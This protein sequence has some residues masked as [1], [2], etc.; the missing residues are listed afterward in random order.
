[1]VL[2]LI[3][4]LVVAFCTTSQ[5]I[6]SRLLITGVAAPGADDGLWEQQT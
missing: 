1:V 3:L 6:T 5:L 4:I 2:N